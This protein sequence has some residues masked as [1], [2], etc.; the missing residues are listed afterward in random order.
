MA[1]TLEEAQAAFKKRYEEVMGRSSQWGSPLE[2]VVSA[3]KRGARWNYSPATRR[4]ITEDLLLAHG[5]SPPDAR[6][7]SPLRVGHVELPDR[8]CARG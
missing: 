1:D 2:N 4:G 5:F 7:L 6:W 3:Q 8:T